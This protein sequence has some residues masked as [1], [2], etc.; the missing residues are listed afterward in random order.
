MLL[1]LRLRACLQRHRCAVQRSRTVTAIAASTH[2]FLVIAARRDAVRPKGEETGTTPGRAGDGAGDGGE[3]G[4]GRALP[5]KPIGC[6]GVA[7]AVIFA[8]E[9]RAGFEP[10]PGRAAVAWQPVQEP[11]AFLIKAAKGLLLQVPSDRPSRSLLRAAGGVRPNTTRQRRRRASSASERRRAISA[12]IAAASVHCC[13][14][15]T[16]SADHPR[17]RRAPCRQR[18]DTPARHRPSQTR[19]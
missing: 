13:C 11:Q 18:S 1:G 6:D 8:N 19:A 12:S 10:A 5:L 3:A 17:C 15:A 2:T 14:M 4:V 16:H 7:L 9:H